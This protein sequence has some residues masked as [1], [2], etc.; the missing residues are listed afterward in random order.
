MNARARLTHDRS[1]KDGSVSAALVSRPLAYQADP[2][3]QGMP[4]DD[5]Q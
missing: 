1:L 3:L 4:R 2:G 5:H